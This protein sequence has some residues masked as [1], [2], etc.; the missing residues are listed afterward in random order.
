MADIRIASDDPVAEVGR[1][2]GRRRIACKGERRVRV[3]EIVGA[4][5]IEAI[6]DLTRTK[7]SAAL[8]ASAFSQL[9]G[10]MQ[11]RSLV[12]RFLIRRAS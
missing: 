6:S 3:G 8:M 7:T 11:F 9:D 1:I 10:K 5:W 4:K 12:E 2:E